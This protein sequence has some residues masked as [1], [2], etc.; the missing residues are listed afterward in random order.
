MSLQP[1]SISGEIYICSFVRH[2][3]TTRLYVQEI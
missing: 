1:L 2:I 3:S